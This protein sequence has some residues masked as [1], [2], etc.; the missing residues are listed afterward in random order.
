MYTAD[1]PAFGPFKVVE[2]VTDVTI[3]LPHAVKMV[4]PIFK[5]FNLWM[6]R[7]GYLWDSVPADN[8]G[9]VVSLVNKGANDYKY[10]RK[11]NESSYVVRKVIPEQLIYLD[12]LPIQIINGTG[13]GHTVVSL[14]GE[15][16]RTKIDFFM[17]HTGYSETASIG[18]L[19]DEINKSM[20]AGTAFWRDYF[21]PDL[22]AAIEA[23]LAGSSSR[24]K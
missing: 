4:W 1:R 22:V 6:N 23:A 13:T 9:N 10:G 12:Q 18:E 11:G 24:H 21:I 20:E 14:S 3:T 19:R 15:H 5:E 7:F 17:E 2:F 8:E 16:G